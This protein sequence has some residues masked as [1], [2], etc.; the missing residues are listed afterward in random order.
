MKRRDLLKMLGF[1]VA[2]PLVKLPK[3]EATDWQNNDTDP[4]EGIY[5][6]EMAEKG[7]LSNGSLHDTG[8]AV[9][10]YVPRYVE[11]EIDLVGVDEA[12]DPMTVEE[13]FRLWMSGDATETALNVGV[14]G[15]HRLLCGDSASADDVDRLLSGAEI[16]L[17]NT[18]P[19]YNVRVEPRSNNA[20]AAGNSS[21]TGD[22]R[23]TG[24]M[25]P[26]DRP[27]ENDFLSDEEFNRLL[28]AW[29]GNMSRVLLGDARS[30]HRAAQ[31]CP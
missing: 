18:D 3:Q 31:A 12:H 20:I 30:D 4:D 2:A 14:L 25:R 28:D 29:F 5:T 24:K 23:P 10:R 6:S 1:G 17:V 21:F 15:R 19:P 22:V 7:A 26:K 27:L 8:V 11:V 9:P 16:H 13:A